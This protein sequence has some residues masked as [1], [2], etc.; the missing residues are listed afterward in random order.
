MEKLEELLE[1]LFERREDDRVE[2]KAE[3]SGNATN[4]YIYF[5]PDQKDDKG[6]NKYFHRLTIYINGEF[7]FIEISYGN[8]KDDEV[9]FKDDT[10]IDTWSEKIENYLETKKSE[11]FDNLINTAF[12]DAYKKDFLRDWKMIKILDKNEPL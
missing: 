4:Y 11:I 10:L 2:F 1:F 5:T 3:V 7:K 6:L 9:T 12:S 8:S